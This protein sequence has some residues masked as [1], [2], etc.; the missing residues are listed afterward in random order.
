MI[1]SS[2]KK[3]QTLILSFLLALLVQVAIYYR[4]DITPFGD[5]SL[6]VTDMNGQYVAYFAYLK[7]A[8]LGQDSLLYSFSK[9]MSGNMIGLT[10]YYLLSP[11]NLVFLFFPLQAFPL[12]ITVV[13]SLKLATAS[14]AMTWLLTKRKLQ[15]WA[16]LA[17]GL[18]YGL[19]AYLMA[20]QQNIMWLEACILFPFLIF[21]LDRL[22]KED[23]WQAYTLVLALALLNN[24]YM[25]AILCLFSLIYF[26]C[27][28]LSAFTCPGSWQA[29]KRAFKAFVPASL[30]AGAMACLTLIPSLLSL[31][32]GKAGFDPSQLVDFHSQFSFLDFSSKLVIGAFQAGDTKSG[33]ANIFVPSLILL[34]SLAGLFNP[35]MS[36]AK[37]VR[38]GL[39]LLSLYLS[40]KFF[41]LNLIW[42]GFNEPTW[43]PFRYSFLFS[44]LL[45][46]MAGE[47][48][49]ARHFSL[50]C[51]G[52]AFALLTGLAWRIGQAHYPYLG[53][54]DI[55]T[56][57]ACLGL[58]LVLLSARNLLRQPS[59][60]QVFGLGLVLLVAYETFTNGYYTLNKM[61]YQ[62]A[63]AF[64]QFVSR[65]QAPIQDLK[66]KHP[67][68]YRL[69]KNQHYANNDPLLLNYPGLS[70]YSS[71]ERAEVIEVMGKLGFHDNGNW[72]RF[73]Y[74]S[75]L[76]ANQWMGLR[77]LLSDHPLLGLSLGQKQGDLYLY[78][79]PLAFPLAYEITPD[80]SFRNP[81]QSFAFQ[82]ELFAYTTG[83]EDYYQPLAANAL[84][85]RLE[86][87][88][89]SESK[90]QIRYSRLD[91]KK[92]GRIHYQ[93]RKSPDQI[94]NY[95]FQAKP[96]GP[97]L[98]IYHDQVF[99]H[100]NLGKK[101]HTLHSYDQNTDR[102]D[103]TVSFHEDKL[104]DP[105]P[106]FYL[107]SRQQTQEMA[108]VAQANAL[109][110][111]DFSPTAIRGRTKGQAQGS[112]LFFSLPYD[113][114]WHA[115]VDGR[116]TPV[117]REA[118]YF[119]GLDLGPG[120]HQVQLIFIPR[121]LI[122]GGA[123]SL[124]SIFIFL[125]SL[126]KKKGLKSSK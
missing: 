105:Q 66:A 124:V 57:L 60:Q 18:A 8:L 116:Y 103:I 64:S 67:G 126:N 9:T 94:V 1:I 44:G 29:I 85:V 76:A 33:L 107:S 24:Y 115:F 112:R 17:L 47:E 123:I 119:L 55:L 100:I 97:G 46:L 14:A 118:Q 90:G 110:I 114:G 36:R 20:Y 42:H 79:N 102:V 12:A 125:K 59:S 41:N 122:L 48:L 50:W 15:A 77:Y 111:E 84:T 101:N 96:V 113:K 31:Q 108:Q 53:R 32:G 75:T 21:A 61:G 63:Q 87:V 121:G 28:C 71:N 89:A 35:A 70:H 68:P 3:H 38:G 13:T 49:K 39:L 23:K 2:L 99:S 26:I 82:N 69:E 30:L 7:N 104:A 80:R 62:P 106:N 74:G 27:W 78:E 73:A 5:Q 117:H 95:Q 40:M 51:Y 81:S 4:L 16:A 54:T 10:N 88:R 120:P 56:S 109:T 83:L 52:L 92:P 11:F 43:F 72:A 6:L 65:Y 98:E 22:F 34:V 45:V 93:I 58:G 91:P 37:K 19:S 86:N 25:G